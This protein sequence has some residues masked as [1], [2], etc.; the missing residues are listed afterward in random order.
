MSE[1]RSR[2][3]TFNDE[4]EEARF[5]QDHDSTDYV[6]WSLP[7][8]LVVPNLRPSLKSISLRLPEP[9]LNRLKTLANER[10]VPYQSL[11]KMILSEH[12]AEK[13]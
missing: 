12:L 5:W 13:G 9:M 4:A 8:T 2:I 7:Q 6:D 3:P 11:I 10:D 1:K